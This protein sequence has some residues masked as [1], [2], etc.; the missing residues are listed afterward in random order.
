MDDPSA[1]QQAEQYR[2]TIASL[3][4]DATT[5]GKARDLLATLK[6]KVARDTG[7]TDTAS[8]AQKSVDNAQHAAER[9]LRILEAGFP[10]VNMPSGWLEGFPAPDPRPHARTTPRWTVGVSVVLFPILYGFAIWS[11]LA[12]TEWKLAEKETVGF[13][14]V[15]PGGIALLLGGIIRRWGSWPFRNRNEQALKKT[16]LP[17]NAKHFLSYPTEAARAEREAKDTG[18]FDAVLAVAPPEVF[19]QEA[20]GPFWVI[21]VGRRKSYLGTTERFQVYKHAGERQAQGG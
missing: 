21:G 19:R 15:L 1:E 14:L 7:V 4:E 6:T 18:L 10:L 17:L 20:M 13:G 12:L 9:T 16:G 5:I 8:H 11:I 3:Q 2:T